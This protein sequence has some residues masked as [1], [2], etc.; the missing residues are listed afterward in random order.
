MPV[1][2]RGGLTSLS[3]A[4][5]RGASSRSLETP[6]HHRP[7]PDRCALGTGEAAAAA[8]RAMEVFCRSTMLPMHRRV[9]F[10]RVSTTRCPAR[11]PMTSSMSHRFCAA[12]PGQPGSGFLAPPRNWESSRPRSSAFAP[13]APNPSSLHSSGIL[14]AGWG[15]PTR[16]KPGSGDGA[17]SESRTGLWEGLVRSTIE[18]DAAD[19]V[20]KNYSPRTFTF[21][22]PLP[23]RGAPS[24]RQRF[25]WKYHPKNKAKRSPRQIPTIGSRRTNWGIRRERSCFVSTHLTRNCGWH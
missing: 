2:G 15:A 21:V 8:A 1:P 4:S 10:G 22:R 3:R 18:N 11:S 9:R 16:I 20:K 13:P 25:G 7:P 24:P 19:A 6:H 23:L 5:R 14:R 12:D 17:R